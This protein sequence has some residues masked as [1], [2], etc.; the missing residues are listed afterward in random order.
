MRSAAA[1]FSRPSDAA[2]R[3]RC[4]RVACQRCTHRR[5]SGSWQ[6]CWFHCR[7]RYRRPHPLRRQV[8]HPSLR[9]VPRQSLAGRL[10]SLLSCTRPMG[11]CDSL[12]PPGEDVSHPPRALPPCRLVFLRSPPRGRSTSPSGPPTP[13][14]EGN[15]QRHTRC[16]TQRGQMSSNAKKTGKNTYQMH[17][18]SEGDGRR[19]PLGR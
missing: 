7:A 2:R 12:G 9:P 3:A 4:R 18:E 6:Y 15:Q 8:R 13:P 14:C 5:H 16:F 11:G 19:P 1:C 10:V 17:L